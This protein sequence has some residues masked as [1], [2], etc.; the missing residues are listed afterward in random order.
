MSI[1]HGVVSALREAHARGLVH[2]DVKPGNIMV[3]TRDGRLHPR[4]IDFGIA[5]VLEGTTYTLSGAVMGTCRY[6]SPEQVRGEPVGPPSDVY[7]LGAVLYELAT[8]APPFDDG[9]PYALMMAHTTQPVPSMESRRPDVPLVLEQLVLQM[10]AKEASE[11]PSLEEVAERLEALHPREVV[12]IAVQAGSGPNGHHLV[13]VQAGPFLYG[14]DRREVF[15][16]GFA[17]D[18]HPV[19]NRQFAAFLRATDYRPRVARGFLRHWGRKGPPTH[20]LD[21]PV[22]FVDH[23]DASAYAAW[24][25]MR[26]PTEAEWE[27]AA[28]GEEGRR[29]PWGRRSPTPDHANY[30]R[31][32]TTQPVDAHPAGRSPYGIEDLAGNVWEWTSDAQVDGF[33]A[34]GPA[35]NPRRPIGIHGGEAVAKGGCWW[36]DDP[37]ALRTTAR[38]AFPTTHRSDMVGF[39]CAR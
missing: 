26:L 31:R 13:A 19:T 27:K 38:Q 16:D 2:R 18:R 7:A 1:A 23:A 15:L 21:H 17:L 4:V 28:R 33:V 14:P 8:G 12:P 20:L 30:G 9:S 32:G 29:Y 34:D 3:E 39:R 5:R 37:K 24:L 35:T 10:L 22:V 11:R 6:M 36:F 25:G